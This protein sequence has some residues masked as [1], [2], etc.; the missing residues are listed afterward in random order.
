MSSRHVVLIAADGL[1][2]QALSLTANQDNTRDLLTVDESKPA[3]LL[4]GADFATALTRKFHVPC[5]QDLWN[6]LQEAENEKAE[7][8]G[9]DAV[10]IGQDKLIDADDCYVFP[11]ARLLF[12]TKIIGGKPFSRVREIQS[13]TPPT[14]YKAPEKAEAAAAAGE[15]GSSSA[16]A[17]TTGSNPESASTSTG[18]GST[19]SGDQTEAD[20]S[21]EQTGG[22]PQ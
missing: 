20:G 8:E 15:S 14:V 18:D 9:R 3:A 5:A 22:N 17:S 4:Q 2:V 1:A 21:T 12:G 6:Q 7:A 16:A 11:D 10:A 13:L 19:G